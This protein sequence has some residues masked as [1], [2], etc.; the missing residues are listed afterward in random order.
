[1]LDK[2]FVVKLKSVLE[3]PKLRQVP[4]SGSEG[5]E[6]DC[7]SVRIKQGDV[8]YIGERVE[9]NSLHALA[10]VEGDQEFNEPVELSLGGLSTFEFEIRHYHGLV[11]HIYYTKREFLWY[12]CTGYYKLVSFY[13]LAKY[14]VP[15]FF[16]SKKLLK[17]P[18]RIKVLETLD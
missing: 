9:G 3:V 8:N 15:K 7:Y 13:V 10:L 11:D 14:R 5:A 17:R 18:N 16:N 6:V 1:M 12:E 2:W 4:R